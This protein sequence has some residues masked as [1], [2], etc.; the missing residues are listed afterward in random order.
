MTDKEI[1]ELLKPSVAELSIVRALLE[2][3]GFEQVASKVL[4]IQARLDSVI[5]KLKKEN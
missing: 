1:I 5:G 3:N 4:S 2:D